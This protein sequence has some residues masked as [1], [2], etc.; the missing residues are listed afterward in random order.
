MS[1]ITLA[2]LGQES[3]PRRSADN[4]VK[5]A[6]TK[7][8]IAI[9][10]QSQ[11]VLPQVLPAIGATAAG[12]MAALNAFQPWSEPSAAEIAAR[13]IGNAGL[14]WVWYGKWDSSQT[15]RANLQ[16]ALNNVR[17]R[18]GQREGAVLGQ[19]RDVNVWAET[20]RETPAAVEQRAR[21]LAA[22]GASAVECVAN[23]LVC[24]WDETTPGQKIAI[25]VGAAA[26]IGIP[27]LFY[28]GG[29]ISAAGN[30]LARVTKNSEKRRHIGWSDPR[31][32][33]CRGCGDVGDAPLCKKC[34]EGGVF[35]QHY[36]DVLVARKPMAKGH[37]VLK[38]SLLL[39]AKR[40][41]KSRRI[42]MGEPKYVAAPGAGVGG[43]I[44]S[45]YA[46]MPCALGCGANSK[47]VYGV[48]KACAPAFMANIEK[49]AAS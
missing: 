7:N 31:L 34:E 42:S 11:A 33:K 36:A 9:N 3:A 46:E 4:D 43:A 18:S 44:R 14:Y 29:F 35:P 37:S 12:V 40:A 2:D 47:S 22:K 10:A 17:V 26:L 28:F 32:T 16:A 27:T 30:V 8:A 20:A 6:F 1:Y 19:Q 39:D 48:C 41:E 49:S 38:K 25:G 13:S 45:Y 21:E 15:I 23:P 5:R 24:F